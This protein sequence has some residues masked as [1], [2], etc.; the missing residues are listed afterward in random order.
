LSSPIDA[1][2]YRRARAIFLAA[3]D[4]GP[5]ERE[6]LVRDGCEGDADLRREVEE[7]LEAD[8][9]P[10]GKTVGAIG[11]SLEP[12]V[13]G[14]S[15][16]GRRIGRYRVLREIGTGGMGRVYEA[17]QD[18]PQ[19]S[20]AL[21]VMRS[22]VATPEVLRRFEFEVELLAQLRHPGIAQVFEAGTFDNGEEQVPW[23]AMELVAGARAVDV[24]VREA[25]L[26]L[27]ERL[28]LVAE[29]CDAVHHGHQRGIVH[30]DLKPG[31]VLVD[32][33]GRPRVIDF[34]VAKSTNSDIAVTTLHTRLGALV[35]TLQYMSPE[36]CDSDPAAID[37]RTDVYS[38][39]VILYELLCE[40][41][42]YDVSGRSLPSAARTVREQEPERPS[43][44]RR[45]LRGD[46]EAIVL[47]AIE[48]QRERRYGSAA[49]LA[50]DLRR[51]LAGEPVEARPA[52]LRW[53][54]SRWIGRRPI[55]ATTI[56]CAMIVVFAAAA[57]LITLEYTL[58]RPDHLVL[59]PARRVLRLVSRAGKPLHEWDSRADGGFLLT[60]DVIR[61]TPAGDQRLLIVGWSEIARSDRAG[62]F[63][64]HDARRPEATVWGS[65]DA[66][67]VP[68]ADEPERA[69]AKYVLRSLLVE[70]VLPGTPGKEIV[71]LFRLNLYSAST[72]RI[73]DL[74]GGLLYEAWHD[75]ALDA[76]RWHPMAHRLVVTGLDSEFR[77]DQR[78]V[79]SEK[80][81]YPAVVFALE[82]RGGRVGSPQ[83]LV[84]RGERRDPSLAWYKWLGPA[85]SVVALHTVVPFFNDVANRLE[86]GSMTSLRFV[87]FATDSDQPKKPSLGFVLD[88]DGR[89]LTRYAADE[90]KSLRDA[91]VLPNEKTF[92]LLDFED[93]PAGAH[94]AGGPR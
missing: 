31:N 88:S 82:P 39:G 87:G 12:L 60:E 30:R 2:R 27:R 4:A 90:Y 26:G 49:D 53:R 22:L 85:E 23:F 21:K 54:V 71:A 52:T 43:A 62:E 74:D 20:V 77:W 11:S 65:R 83:W 44:V 93:L 25:N 37:A 19:R 47:K 55:L 16:V 80:G 92:D 86:A 94:E 64:V 41:P 63:T 51:H 73:Y 6:R 34:G 48:K 1:T 75:G 7:L 58:R 18:S 8:S 17:V 67:F 5:G 59:D 29:V 81:D 35:G 79:R 66:M 56:A 84:R 89:I 9:R 50:A 38:L 28:E 70:D 69:E 57:A 91:G 72:V 3:V 32:A 10:G 45:A 13:L 46:L 61:T 24:H 14:R 76:V 36:Q 15:L 68:P 78:G 33:D 42:P 40:R